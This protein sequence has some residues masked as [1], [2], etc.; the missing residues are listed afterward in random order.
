VL[1]D[2]TVVLFGGLDEKLFN[3]NALND[4]W[5]LSLLSVETIPGKYKWFQPQIGLGDK[6]TSLKPNARYHH[7]ASVFEN[8]LVI[9]GGN[10]SHSKFLND[11][12][13][14]ENKKK[15]KDKYSLHY[16][17]WTCLHEGSPSNKKDEEEENIPIK[18][19]EHSSTIIDSKMYIFGGN[20]NSKVLN[21]LWCFDLDNN[22]WSEIK[23]KF[24]VPTPR[25]GHCCCSIGNFIYILFGIGTNYKYQ[26]DFSMDNVYSFDIYEEE[27]KQI[28]GF[29]DTLIL[30]GATCLTHEIDKILVHGGAK[31]NIIK[32]EYENIPNIW[33]YDTCLLVNKKI[34]KKKQYINN[35]EIMKRLGGGSQGLVYLVKKKDSSEVYALKTID[36]SQEED[37]EL[38]KKSDEEILKSLFHLREIKIYQ[39]L[40]HKN[41]VEMKDHFIR[42]KH[43]TVELCFLFSYCDVG[44]LSKYIKSKELSESEILEICAGILEGLNYCHS[45]SIVHRD[46]KPENIF[47]TR[48]NGVNVIKLG[49]L[50]LNEF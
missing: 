37:E 18:R 40:N 29:D 49:G 23:C 10:S 35:Y 20:S 4:V 38:D 13:M 12:W 6:L 28:Q 41:I 43:E 27:W 26:N 46:L 34:K 16:I 1:K 39:Q 36:L 25:Y 8:K 31:Y 5:I 47:I 32:D 17:Q 15:K 48:E 9:F 50:F 11:V 45:K 7:T 22:Q 24:N 2:E 14:L 30:V 3:S 21:D 33:I 19:S 42:R 44:D